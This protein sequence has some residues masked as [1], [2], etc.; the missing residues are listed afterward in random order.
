MRK[1]EA[2]FDDDVQHPDQVKAFVKK[3]PGKDKQTAL[4]THDMSLIR[5]GSKIA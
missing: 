4:C 2:A 5:T 3:H 1:E